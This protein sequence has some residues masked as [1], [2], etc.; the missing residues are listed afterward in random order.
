LVRASGQAF[1]S[2]FETGYHPAVAISIGIVCGIAPQTKIKLARRLRLK[3]AM[4][5]RCLATQL[6]TWPAGF[7]ANR[8]RKAK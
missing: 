1:S 3:N 6:R 7:L 8:R 2:G 4:T 5:L